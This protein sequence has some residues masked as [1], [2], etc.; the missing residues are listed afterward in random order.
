M[1]VRTP[2]PP[3]QVH[4]HAVGCCLHDLCLGLSISMD[5]METDYGT[6]VK[7]IFH[8]KTGTLEGDEHLVKQFAAF[9]TVT[10]IYADSLFCSLSIC[11][12]NGKCSPLFL[13]TVKHFL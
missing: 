12:N 13:C 7:D 3:T 8:R 5:M 1:T 10:E 4:G 11:I 6:I 9:A 2:S